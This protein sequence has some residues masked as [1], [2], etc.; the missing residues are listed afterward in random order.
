M[1]DTQTAP[2]MYWGAIRRLA[3]RRDRKRA[4][5][6]AVAAIIFLCLIVIELPPLVI[7]PLW[8]ASCLIFC[9]NLSDWSF[10]GAQ[11]R[12]RIVDRLSF[13]RGV[14]YARQL[15]EK[16]KGVAFDD[17]LLGLYLDEVDENAL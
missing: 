6:A 11:K 12:W 17:Q 7:F 15:L 9:I 1:S 8:A 2:V 14:E 16:Y 10:S 13:D 3:S 5:V 4:Y